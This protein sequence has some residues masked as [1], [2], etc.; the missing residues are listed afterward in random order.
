MKNCS[1]CG[2]DKHLSLF[3]KDKS[4]RDGRC[5]ICKDCK[6]EY[7]RDY[8]SDNA[9]KA[10]ADSLRWY[11]ENRERA[12]ETRRSYHWKHIDYIRSARKRKYWED[13]ESAKRDVRNYNRNRAREDPVFR[14]ILRCRKRTWAAFCEGGYTKRSKTF[15]LIGCD[16]SGLVNHLEAQF[17]EGMSWDNYGEWHVDHIVP[18]SSAKSE[19]DVMKLC[20]YTNL[21]PLWA[22]DNIR[23]G[24]R[25]EDSPDSVTT[26]TRT[27]IRAA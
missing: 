12:K 27:D 9:E 6:S 13:P 8:Y 22:Q 14:L 11:R 5:T 20:H 4:K 2:E 21:Q 26:Q 1:K 18:L 10:R 24:A 25:L 7:R 23:K 15:D 16:V 3:S 17:S 19:A